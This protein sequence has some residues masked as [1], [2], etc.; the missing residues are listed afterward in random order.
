MHKEY[1]KDEAKY[2]L[3]C[4]MMEASYMKMVQDAI[5]SERAK[6]MWMTRS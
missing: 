3:S 1:L 2:L 4:K 6:Q 5:G